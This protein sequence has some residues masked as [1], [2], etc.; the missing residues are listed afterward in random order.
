MQYIRNATV[1]ASD[2]II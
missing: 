1:I 2:G